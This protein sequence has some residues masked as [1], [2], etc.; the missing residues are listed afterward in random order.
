MG[1]LKLFTTITR[2]EF[3]G[4]DITATT[5]ACGDGCCYV[6]KDLLWVQVVQT[7]QDKFALQLVP[8][9]NADPM[10]I[11][12]VYKNTIM[13]E[14]REVP[15]ELAAAYIRETTGIEIA[16]SLPGQ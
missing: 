14:S 2:Q 5:Y 8:A 10:G 6:M 16:S 13:L 3:I 4:Q 1:P 15:K 12:I 7:A 9:S 11:Q